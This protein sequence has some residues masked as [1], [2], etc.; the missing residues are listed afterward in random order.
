MKWQRSDDWV[1]SE[2]DDSFVMVNIDSGNYVALNI[3]ANAVW[4]A[5]ET[6]SSEDELVDRLTGKFDIDAE[7]CRTSVNTLLGKMQEMAL[8]SQG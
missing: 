8:V 7:Q 3:T 6:P 4:Q 2:I 5:L 1:G